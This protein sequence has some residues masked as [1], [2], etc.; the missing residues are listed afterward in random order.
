MYATLYLEGYTTRHTG[1]IIHRTGQ[2]RWYTLLV[3]WCA[4]LFVGSAINRTHNGEIMCVC[5]PLYS[6]VILDL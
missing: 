5:I 6:T 2:R 1:T 4:F 3:W